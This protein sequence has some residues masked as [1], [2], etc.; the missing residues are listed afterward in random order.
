MALTR[1]DGSAPFGEPAPRRL[2]VD[3]AAV[4]FSAAT[5]FEGAR[6]DHVFKMGEH[7]LGYYREGPAGEWRLRARVRVRV[8]VIVRVRVREGKG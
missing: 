1:A 8:R 6:P 3:A 4:G 7:G 2:G 5:T